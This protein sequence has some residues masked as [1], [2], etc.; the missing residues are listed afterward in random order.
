LK[1]SKI[2][3][4]GDYPKH[5]RGLGTNRH[6]GNQLQRERG[7]K[8]GKYGPAS[9]VR[10]YT[11][12]EKQSVS[13]RLGLE[14]PTKGS[15]T[16]NMIRSRLEREE[17]FERHVLKLLREAA[18]CTGDK[19][20]DICNLIADLGAVEVA[21]MLVDPTEVRNPPDGFRRLMK[22]NLAQ[23]TIEQ[24]IVDFADRGI[25]TSEEIRAAKARLAIFRKGDVRQHRKQTSR[26]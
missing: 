3:S 4:I 17:Q 9:S 23:L 7:L 24:A 16:H 19:L 11:E 18:R 21:K 13:E 12:A 20:G 14:S 26:K 22:N 10:T 25:F 15:G 2:K 1:K 5:L 8:G 6:G